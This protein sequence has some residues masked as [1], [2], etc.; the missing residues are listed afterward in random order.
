[1]TALRLLALACVVMVAA[2]APAA[3]RRRSRSPP[4]AAASTREVFAHDR[5]VRRRR[6]IKD[7]QDDPQPPRAGHRLGVGEPAA[8]GRELV[9]RVGPCLGQLD[10]ERVVDRESDDRDGV[11]VDDEQ[12]QRSA[13]THRDTADRRGGAAA[14]GDGGRRGWLVDPVHDRRAD[15]LH[16]VRRPTNSVNA[17]EPRLRREHPAAGVRAAHRRA[18]ARPARRVGGSGLLPAG[19]YSLIS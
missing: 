17:D 13:S 7:R 14:R 8:R 15:G 9:D 3:A 18:R 11:H 12:R 16:P 19:H 4:R 10:A 5:R 1:M 6:V 2:V